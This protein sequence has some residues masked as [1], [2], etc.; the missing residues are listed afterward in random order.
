MPFG[1]GNPLA[2]KEIELQAREMR[3]LAREK[4][5]DN[6]MPSELAS[7]LTCVNEKDL[8]EKIEILKKFISTDKKAELITGFKIGAPGQ[9]TRPKV[10]PIREAMGL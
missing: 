3:L 1:E 9:E 8:N 7:V 10:D 4:L 6:N 2:A 5:A